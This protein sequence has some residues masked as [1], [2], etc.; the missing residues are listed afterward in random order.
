[1]NAPLP[2]IMTPSGEKT[3]RE[4]ANETGMHF[5]TLRVRYKNN[6]S[7]TYEE[8]ISK[9]KIQKLPREIDR[10]KPEAFKD[11]TWNEL[12]ETYTLIKGSTGLAAIIA[13]MLR[14]PKSEVKP[15]IKNWRR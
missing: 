3:I 14:I 8:L 2:K 11:Y 7:I 9:N 12:V 13:D 15:I 5:E 1:M 4:I 10:S 6:P